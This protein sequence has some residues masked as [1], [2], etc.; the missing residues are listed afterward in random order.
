MSV[1]FPKPFLPEGKLPASG[2]SVGDPGD[3][4]SWDDWDT[5]DIVDG[6]LIR[7]N[8]AAI[9]SHVNGNLNGTDIAPTAQLG[10]E[11]ALVD[12]W[13]GGNNAWPTVGA[14]HSHDGLDSASLG[15]SLIGYS[16]LAPLAHGALMTPS[17][18]YRGL[19]L[20]GR[21]VVTTSQAD[22]VGVFDSRQRVSVPYNYRLWSSDPASHTY[23]FRDTSGCAHICCSVE[24]PD[25][26]SWSNEERIAMSVPYIDPS[27]TSNKI[28]VFYV[29]VMPDTLKIPAGFA[30]HWVVT[31]L[32]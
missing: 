15:E 22:T 24:A 5:K 8:F 23:M 7:R 17:M 12:D 14:R 13:E 10:T 18:S 32:V 20:F 29:G 21:L 16:H 19:T 4:A 25:S 31:G 28:T 9:F 27:I 26:D 3:Y 2:A 11:T 6:D 1:I 30:F